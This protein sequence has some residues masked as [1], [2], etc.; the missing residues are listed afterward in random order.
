MVRY[1][2]PRQ[3]VIDDKPTPV[4]FWEPERLYQG[5]TVTI[6]GG[7][8]S[9]ADIDLEVLRGHRFIAVNSS[10]RKVQ[11]IST[12][13][14]MLY[15]TDNSWNENRP[16]LVNEWPGL[17]VTSNRNAKARLKDK[18]LRIDVADLVQRLE[19]FPDCM[20]TSSGHTAAGFAAVLGAKRI[21]LIGFDCRMVNG[22]SHGHGD[23]TQPDPNSFQLR[24]IPSWEGMAKV[25]ARL[26]IPVI[27]ATPDSAVKCFPFLTLGE[28]LRDDYR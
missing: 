18:V 6:I 5:L 4:P 11:P 17:V 3:I 14:D 7:G 20:Y 28:A 1:V 8:P 27:N 19:V 25:F 10:C 26:N 22:R 9:H 13:D 24:Y 23:Y 16:Q 15:F 12:K 21:V 2:G